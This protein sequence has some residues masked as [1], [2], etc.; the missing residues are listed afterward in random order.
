MP[1]VICIG[2]DLYNGMPADY[3]SVI[4]E[5]GKKAGEFGTQFEIKSEK[6]FE[7]KLEIEGKMIINEIPDKSSFV[8]KLAPLY[9]EYESRIGKDLLTMIQN[10]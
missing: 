9:Q 10:Q 7:N 6:E 3:Q 1:N 8:G 5:A 2:S 4:T